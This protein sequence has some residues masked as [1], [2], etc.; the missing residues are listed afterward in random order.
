MRSLLISCCLLLLTACGAEAPDIKLENA[1]IT[2]PIGGR[3]IA[4]G[5]ISLTA[6]GQDLRL[7]AVTS[8]AADRIEIHDSIQSDIGRVQM[9]RLEDLTIEA[10]TTRELGTGGA[11]LMIF[12]FDENLVPGDTTELTLRFTQGTGLEQT[13]TVTA[14][15]T[16]LGD[17]TGVHAGHGG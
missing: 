4:L 8:P 1:K 12:G 15:I 5:G 6:I 14:I 17:D 16:E 13:R 10:G 2:D 3:D 7:L 9:R 11:H